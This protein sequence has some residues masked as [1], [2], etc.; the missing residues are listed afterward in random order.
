MKILIADDD[1]VTLHILTEFLHE[2][3]YEIVTARDGREAWE[4]LQR[5]DAPS[6]LILDWLMPGMSGPAICLEVRKRSDLPYT[7]ILLLTV[8]DQIPDV[9]EG[10]GAGADDYLTKPFDV[11]ELEARLR[12]GERILKLQETLRHQATHDSLTGL[13]NRGTILDLL[14]RELARGKRKATPIAVIMADIDHFKQV[15]DTYGHA[16]GDSVLREVAARMRA[17]LRGYDGVG[18]YGGEEFL[19]VLPECSASGGAGI[20]KRIREEISER[21]IDSNG[22]SIR[23]SLSLGVASSEGAGESDAESLLVSADQALYRAKAQGRNRVELA[24]RAEPAT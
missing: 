6:L 3:G 18:R 2:R 16:A 14:S 11:R 20:A 12:A 4:M 21:P 8:K 7:Y 22:V 1:N 23:L 24:P 5:A 10:M 13:W 15:N 19:T 17:A 9:V